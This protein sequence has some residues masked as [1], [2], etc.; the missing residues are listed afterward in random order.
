MSAEVK[1]TKKT[2]ARPSY[3]KCLLWSTSTSFLGTKAEHNA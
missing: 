2:Y 3:S 1:F